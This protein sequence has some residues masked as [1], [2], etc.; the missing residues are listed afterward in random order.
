MHDFQLLGIIVEVVARSAQLKATKTLYSSNRAPAL[1]KLR[2]TALFL[3]RAK[4]ELS[5]AEIGRPF[6]RDHSSVHTAIQRE[7]E[8]LKRNIP[9]SDKSTWTEYHARLS[10]EI[11]KMIADA[12]VAALPN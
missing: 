12:V 8:R 6:G 7:T 11:D 4:T 3:I 1:V 5:L 9:R 10:T 2:D